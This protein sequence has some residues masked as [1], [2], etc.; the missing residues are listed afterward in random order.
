MRNGQKN[1][2]LFILSILKNPKEEY[3]P[4]SLAKLMK[5]SAMGSL[6][7]AKKLEK[8]NVLKSRKVGRASIYKIDF[9][10][11]SK[12][13]IKFL[14]KKEVNDANPY[15]KRWARDLEKVKSANALVLYGS[16]LIKGEGARDIDVLVIV[17]K[18]NINRVKKEIE[19]LNLIND[20]KIHPLYQTKQ[21][22]VKHIREG[23]P[24]VLNA[25]KGV[26][27]FGADLMLEVLE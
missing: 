14:L 27:L 2:M 11:Y 4:N 16:V 6:K 10:D 18:N 25:L 20:K 3:N 23:N 15:V 9:N 8:E 13:Y 21:D 26:Y 19:S 22:L 12:Q 1:E 24:V 7:I 5:I 17:N